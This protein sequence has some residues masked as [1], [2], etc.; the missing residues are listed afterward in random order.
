MLPHVAR[1]ICY[2][3]L[4]ARWRRSGSRR[5]PRPRHRH[6][7]LPGPRLLRLANARSIPI[8]Q[9]IAERFADLDRAA[10][11]RRAEDQDLR[12]H[13]RLRPSPCRPHRHPRRRQEGR[14]VLPDHAR[15]L[16]D[17]DRLARRHPR[18]RRSPTTRSSTRSR[19]LVDTYLGNCAATASASSTPI[20]ASASSR[21]RR[22]S[23][24]LIKNGRIR[25]RTRAI[26]VA[27]DEPLPADGR[28]DRVARALAR[29]ARGAAGARRRRSACGCAAAEPPR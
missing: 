3:A 9:R 27:D 4:A 20:A 5:Q 8:A 10:R 29:R 15:R 23:M 26:A 13:Q 16:G 7:R 6:H 14:G 28:G 18:A 21:S 2:G 24:P 12:L 25:R 11:H 17:R 19:P 22:G 1:T